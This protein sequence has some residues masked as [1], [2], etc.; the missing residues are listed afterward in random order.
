VARLVAGMRGH[1][2]VD[3]ATGDGWCAVGVVCGVGSCRGGGGLSYVRAHNETRTTS[4][5]RYT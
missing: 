4:G 2:P 3:V 1:R 5:S